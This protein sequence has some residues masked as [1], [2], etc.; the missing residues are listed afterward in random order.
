MPFQED[1]QAAQ[2]LRHAAGL[3]AFEQRGQLA[4]EVRVGLHG[5]PEQRGDEHYQQR[6]VRAPAQAAQRLHFRLARLPEGRRH[7]FDRGPFRFLG[8]RTGAGA[9][10]Q[11]GDFQGSG[12]QQPRAQGLFQGRPGQGRLDLLFTERVQRNGI[13]KGPQGSVEFFFQAALPG[14]LAALPQGFAGQEDL[15]GQPGA[16]VGLAQGPAHVGGGRPQGL[17]RHGPRTILPTH[18]LGATEQATQSQTGEGLKAARGRLVLRRGGR[19]VPESQN[20]VV[21]VQRDVPQGK[22]AA[23][24]MVCS[25]FNGLRP[26]RQ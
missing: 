2:V 17:R 22:D 23:S 12:G 18:R 15:D 5:V 25:E 8:L 1:T 11:V 3:A 9:L 14:D 4:E 16:V 10:Q 6:V 7:P 21:Q 20:A 24:T 19:A 13:E 26:G